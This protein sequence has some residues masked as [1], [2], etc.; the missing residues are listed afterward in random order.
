MFGLLDTT[1]TMCMEWLMPHE[2]SSILHSTSPLKPLIYS[3][4]AGF[5]EMKTKILSLLED[6][7]KRKREKKR[8]LEEDAEKKNKRLRLEAT[9][10]DDLLPPNKNKGFKM[11]TYSWSQTL[12]DIEVQ[13]PVLFGTQ[14]EKNLQYVI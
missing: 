2:G 1:C 11:K 10:D 12:E 8:E 7:K 14:K 5:D 9:T 13:V 4:I 6:I 3:K